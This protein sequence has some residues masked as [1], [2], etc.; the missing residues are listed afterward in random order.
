MVPRRIRS[1]FAVPLLLAGMAVLSPTPAQAG[2]GAET[3]ITMISE[4]EDWIGGGAHRFFDP[5]NASI[6]LVGN[7]SYVNVRV[8][9]GNFGNEEFTFDFAAPPGEV[10]K[11][12]EYERAQRY[13]FQEPPHPGLAVWGSG[14]ACN[15][16]TGRFR[17][18]EITMDSSGAPTSVWILYEQDCELRGGP[19]LFGEVRVNVS[20]DGGKAAAGPREIRWPSADPGSQMRIV[21]FVIRNTAQTNVAIGGA[22]I[23]GPSEAAFGVTADDCAG[24]I[25]QPGVECR[26]F[27]RWTPGPAGINS[28]TLLV[29]EVGG[30]THALALEGYS[31]P[32]RTR[33]VM[34]SDPGDAIG[35]GRPW[36]F[37]P[38]DS[39][40]AA[41][42]SYQ[43]VE[44][45]AYSS[46]DYWS[47]QVAAPS[48]DSLTAGTT[49]R[50]AT[51]SFDGSGPGLSVSGGG[52]CNT[53]SG[54]F[55]INELLVNTYGEVERFAVSFEQHCNGAAPALRGTYEFRASFVDTTPPDLRFERP[56]AGPYV[57]DQSIGGAGPV[58]VV[59]RVRVE[60]RA[61]DLESGISSFG[62]EV[63]G[64][65]VDD[66]QVTEA[67]GVY[68]FEFRPA[69]PGVYDIRARATN[70][71]GESRTI[72]LQ[73]IGVPA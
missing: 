14:R 40:F 69:A 61:H 33:L 46:D 65:P 57:N 24:R 29:P 44:G 72:S 64:Q 26:V 70:A 13:P 6:T 51:G 22:S 1:L 52:Q 25:L 34:T 49:Y 12:G 60:V 32:G 58:V 17:V 66:S 4:P 23:A 42:G 59:G 47:V 39:T 68:R 11:V 50:N 55:T 28:A 63:N 5:K 45:I 73:V 53:L 18:K 20:G 67:S 35:S 71:A 9:G 31:Y 27:V 41:R 10:L 2:S 7:A 38:A 43:Y 62:F 19:V 15:E 37:A 54:E 21:P 8:Q 56:T 36:S 30:P 16:S 48:G 3:F